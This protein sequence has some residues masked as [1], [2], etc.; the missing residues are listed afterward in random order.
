MIST[1]LFDLDGTLLDSAPDL[2]AAMNEQRR[3][4]RMP[5]LPYELLRIHA[6]SGARGMIKAGFGL[7]TDAPEY[8]D[9][10]LEFLEI[11]ERDLLNETRPFPEVG[12]LLTAIEQSGR[13]WGIVTNKSEYLT[14]PLLEAFSLHSRAG[15][16]V[17]GD[18]TPFT[19]PHPAP[20]LEAA[21]R[22][23]V[24]PGLCVYVGD[25]QRDISAARAAG[26]RAVAAAYGYLGDGR[27]P[28]EW[29]ADHVVQAP[30]DILELL[31]IRTTGV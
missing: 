31:S 1:V 6:S 4:R 15:C 20:L 3:R 2:A 27:P 12:E 21:R 5:S 9:L 16:V 29:G 19:K 26:M 7:E 8:Q 17:C 23:S 13:A 11:Y 28:T 24:D 25:D 14:L 18:T 22:L 30:L 10:R